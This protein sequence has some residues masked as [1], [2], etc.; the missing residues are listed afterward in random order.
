MSCSWIKKSLLMLVVL[1]INAAVIEV[2][3]IKLGNTMGIKR[4][5]T[6]LQMCRDSCLAKFFKNHSIKSKDDIIDQCQN[7]NQPDC[8]MCYDFC[9][10]LYKES[11][12][13]VHI[14]CTD[15]R[16]CVSIF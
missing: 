12:T 15:E 9:G 5:F 1:I 7:E 10:L 11:S 3:S 14:M 6:K 16:I 2:Q 4:K 8:Y 13:I